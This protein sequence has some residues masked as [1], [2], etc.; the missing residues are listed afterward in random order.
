M[1]ISASLW[2]QRWTTKTVK[3]RIPKEK[4]S[5]MVD[6]K[7]ENNNNKEEDDEDTKIG[8]DDFV[9]LEDFTNEDEF[10][11]NLRIRFEANIIYVWPH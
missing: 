2:R 9:L 8:L 7:P 10:I 4:T 3:V 5:E 11:N 1:K 6:L